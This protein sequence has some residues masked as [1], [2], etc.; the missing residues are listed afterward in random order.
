MSII[1]DALRRG[2][3][4][5]TPR[6]NTN[7]AQTDAVLQTLGYGRFSSTSPFNRI[8]KIFRIFGYVT[9]AIMF[10]IVIWGA[11]IWITQ[12]YFT[13]EPQMEVYSASG[14]ATPPVTVTPSSTPSVRP[15][16]VP[17]PSTPP[18][19]A[20]QPQPKPAPPVAAQPQ[21]RPVPTPA[22]VAPP[23]RATTPRGGGPPASTSARATVSVA[24]VQ[25]LPIVQ[26]SRRPDVPMDMPV[27]PTGAPS[28]TALSMSAG[29]NAGSIT[30]QADH[31]T[32]A[33]YYQ[34]IGNFEE[35]LIHYRAV[36]QRDE[37]NA[38]AHNNL[39]L[40]YRDK[41]LLDDAVKE[42]QRAI[43]IDQKYVKA[44]NNLGVAYL[45]QRR[46]EAAASEFRDALTLDPRNVESLVN[47]SLAEKDAGRRDDATTTLSRAL[48][49][50]PRNAEAHYNL[51]LIVDDMGDRT[52]ALVHYRAFLQ[53]GATGHPDL[54]GDVRKRIDTLVK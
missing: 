16:P 25:A 30:S 19:A 9:V 11:V 27:A 4:R 36:L 33:L 3:G 26:M 35:S 22:V 52:Q 5:T 37:L 18:P 29:G 51:A 8:R 40:L 47:L 41:G 49:I 10:V 1:L 39:G 44:H 20:V 24:A 2:R 6:P 34:R 7:A 50:D 14:T 48:E 21:P 15:A 31:F 38:E 54:I 42:F 17:A 53:Y 13:P 32:L 28:R 43:V 45:G 46:T 12:A 23:P